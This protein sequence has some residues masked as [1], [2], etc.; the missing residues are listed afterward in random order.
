MGITA[1]CT[2]PGTVALTYVDGPFIY[3]ER[4][5]DILKAKSVKA[6]F[7]INGDSIAK[8]RDYER[9]V[10]RAYKE[11]HQIA[12]HTWSH[13]DLGK[14]SSGKV[15]KEMTDLGNAIKKLI[16]IKPVY[17]RPPFGSLSTTAKR[18]LDPNDIKKSKK[19]IQSAVNGGRKESQNIL[20]HD[21]IE[22]TATTLTP[23][24]IDYIRSKD[25][26]MV[27][28]GECLGKPKSAWYK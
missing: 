26:K 2:V 25:Y 14:M 24:A 13:T 5:L 12:S 21:I 23:R 7:F 1:S 6:T 28:V 22:K 15:R 17:M 20:M 16:G 8:L 3:I 10:K 4:L 18:T 9:I 19:P 27:T 11:G